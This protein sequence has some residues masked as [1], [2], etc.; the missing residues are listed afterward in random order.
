MPRWRYG[1][2]WEPRFRANGTRMAGAG[3]GPSWLAIL[4]VSWAACAEPFYLVSVQEVGAPIVSEKELI[5]RTN[6][7]FRKAPESYWTFYDR[8]GGFLVLDIYGAKL[9]MQTELD[10]SGN[11][12]FKGIK[13]ENLETSMSLSGEQ[14]RVYL[15]V[16]AGWRFEAETMSKSVIQITARKTLA[17]PKP[18]KRKSRRVILYILAAVAA[19]AGTFALIILIGRSG[20]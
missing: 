19:S 11:E 15:K 5:Y 3:R 18:V 13:V 1:A 14:A 2:T 20:D 16:E 9:E 7:V 17:P 12:V 10:L 4:L 6:I 8:Q